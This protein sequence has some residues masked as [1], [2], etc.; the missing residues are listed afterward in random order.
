VRFFRGGG[1]VPVTKP[2]IPL[3]CPILTP[4][5]PPQIITPKID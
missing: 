3:G 4:S 2:P 5:H 1:F